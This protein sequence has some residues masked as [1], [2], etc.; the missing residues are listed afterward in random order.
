[1]ILKLPERLVKEYNNM[2]NTGI[3]S[4]HVY[5]SWNLELSRHKTCS[6]Y[7]MKMYCLT[8]RHTLLLISLLYYSIQRFAL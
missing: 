3:C 7:C 5:Q 8:G 1:M 4:E 6:D 2:S